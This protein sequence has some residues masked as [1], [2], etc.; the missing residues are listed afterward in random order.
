MNFVVKIFDNFQI[1][2]IFAYNPCFCMSK[3]KTKLDFL[4]KNNVNE[5]FFNEDINCALDVLPAIFYGSHSRVRIF[6]RCLS[7]EVSTHPT[8]V[9]ALSDFIERNGKVEV[10]LNGFNAEKAKES[11][12]MRRLAYYAKQ[13]KGITVRKTSSILSFNTAPT[14]PIYFTVGDD[15]AYRVETNPQ[16][17]QAD[18]NM[19]D[20]EFAGKLIN[21]FDR[22]FSESRG[23]AVDL[24]DLFNLK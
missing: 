12:V 13:G 21:T 7:G 15:K 18:C 3:L 24:L 1:L 5:L 17:H 11:P 4:S 22:M 19:N 14:Q 23:Y 2:V 9:Q 16:T 8:Y 6:A 10:L 20:E